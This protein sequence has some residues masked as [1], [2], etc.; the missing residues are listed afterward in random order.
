M[1]HVFFGFLLG[2][3]MGFSN[4]S[5]AQ[6]INTN[7]LTQQQ[8]LELGLQA[9]KMKTEAT[10]P[11][12]ISA[13]VRQE[14]SA[15]AALGS[16]IGVAMVGAAKEIGVAANEFSQTSLGRVV[17]FVVVYKLIG[18][19]MIG[20]VVGAF[21]LL[22]AYSAGLYMWFGRP[23]GNVEYD[24]KPRLFGLWNSRVVTKISFSAPAVEYKIWAG[25]ATM[26]L[27]TI[28]GITCIF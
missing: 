18:N 21:I 2:L 5:F 4:E 13:T 1:K 16:N 19:D 28:V 7:G 9:E 20:F 6:T 24:Y 22:V 11:T 23:W 3:L 15:W 10:N 27:G 25:A 14:A 17:T 26:I 12:N 8:I